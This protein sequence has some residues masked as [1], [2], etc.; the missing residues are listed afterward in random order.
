MTLN[1]CTVS[2]NTAHDGGGIITGGS[3]QSCHVY[4]DLI[5]STVSGN[6]AT[7]WGGG[8]QAWT[9]DCKDITVNLYHSTVATN[10]AHRGGG[11]DGD[12]DVTFTLQNSIVAGNTISDVFPSSFRDCSGG[13]RQS[14]GYNLISAA[15]GCPNNSTTDITPRTPLTED[16]D[17][18]LAD[19]GGFAPTHALPAGSQA[20][21][22]IPAGANGCGTTHTVDQRGEPRPQNG[23]CDIGAYETAGVVLDVHVYLPIV[24]RAFVAPPGR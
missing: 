8:I 5:N 19:N 22:A 16:L 14:Q 18:V 20:I 21:D 7:T 2:D 17:L 24:M 6:Q 4:L 3:F 11:L 13:I 23:R 15:Y 9:W 10:T 1:R 12:G